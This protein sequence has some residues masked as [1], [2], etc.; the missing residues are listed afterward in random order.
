[1]PSI[2][3]ATGGRPREAGNSSQQVKGSRKPALK[4]G[5]CSQQRRFRSKTV[6]LIESGEGRAFS[7]AS[8]AAWAC[9]G[10]QLVETMDL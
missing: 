9:S 1:M 5:N 6:N 7:A 10:A 2:V 4:G 8:R 3:I